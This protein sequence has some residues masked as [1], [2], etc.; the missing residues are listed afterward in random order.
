MIA[1]GSRDEVEA[2]RH[3]QMWNAL[4]ASWNED[5][6]RFREV[7]RGRL[8]ITRD[9]I[10]EAGRAH[11]TIRDALDLADTLAQNMAPGHD[12]QA[13][14]FRLSHTMDALSESIAT[15]IDRL[16]PR[17]ETLEETARLR[18]LVGALRRNADLGA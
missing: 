11:D 15:S 17:T 1:R 8:P 4:I 18:Y 3:V 10:I 16:R 7:A 14:L 12:L 2:Q 13:D 5:A 6:D 9:T